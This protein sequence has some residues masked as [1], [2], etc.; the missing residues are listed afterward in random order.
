[1]PDVTTTSL[2]PDSWE[3]LPDTVMSNFDHDIDGAVADVLKERKAVAA[4][5]GWNFCGYV[6]W[7]SAA[8]EWACEVWVYHEPQEVVRAAE[9][10]D[11]M[12]EVCAT[13]GD[14]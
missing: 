2:I 5:T 8:D 14:D 11:I 9:L 4:Y 1:M 13:Y 10:R 6:W 12:D 3:R 7:D